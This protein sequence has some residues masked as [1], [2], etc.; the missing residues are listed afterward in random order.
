MVETGVNVQR[1]VAYHASP[2]LDTLNAKDNSSLVPDTFPEAW[3]TE[4]GNVA[5]V[6]ALV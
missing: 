2:G 5:S 1:V 6:F 4:S 3:V